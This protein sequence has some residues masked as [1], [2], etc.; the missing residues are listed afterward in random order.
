[1]KKTSYIF[2]FLAGIGVSVQIYMLGPC[3]IAKLQIFVQ[4][5]LAIH[6]LLHLGLLHHKKLLDYLPTELSQ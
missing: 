6:F 1:M 2:Q 4:N 5:Y 3:E